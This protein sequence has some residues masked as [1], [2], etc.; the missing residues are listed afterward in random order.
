MKQSHA[1]FGWPSSRQSCPTGAL[2]EHGKHVKQ[3]TPASC[4]KAPPVAADEEFRQYLYKHQDPDYK[5]RCSQHPGLPLCPCKHKGYW[6]LEDIAPALKLFFQV[7]P[8][9]GALQLVC[10]SANVWARAHQLVL[11]PG[12]WAACSM[13]QCNT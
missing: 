5:T 6:K 9:S 12:R 2:F 11:R 3:R 7:S 8:H 10:S 4:C 1:C 13:K